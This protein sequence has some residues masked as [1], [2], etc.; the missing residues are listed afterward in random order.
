MLSYFRNDHQLRVVWAS[1]NPWVLIFVGTA[2]FHSWRGS[3]EDILIFGGSALLI[4]SQVAGLTRFGFRE[5]PQISPFVIGAVVIAS[6]LA[7]YFSERHGIVNLITLLILIPIGIVLLLY[8]DKQNQLP[9][10][11]PVRRSRLV[12]ATW[13]I[14]FALVELIAYL[15]SKFSGD[16]EQ[17]PTISV[18]L[19]PVLDDPL[20]RAT[21]IA[22]WLICGVYLFGIRRR[23]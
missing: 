23:R 21:F 7:L 18:L 9:P 1:F 8:V 13:A 22:L 3:V 10:S 14:S 5:Q 2:I 20:G 6:A 12:W 16:L 11:G 19:D 15:G 17:F 4:L